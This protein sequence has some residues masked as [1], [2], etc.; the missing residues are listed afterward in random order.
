MTRTLTTV[1]AGLTLIASGGVLDA[2]T[3]KPGDPAPKLFVSEWLNGEPVKQFEEGVV[4]VVEC[5]AT[6]CG[7]CISAIPHVSELNTRYKDQKVVFIGLNVW[8]GQV[9]KVKALLEQMGPKMNY[10]VAIDEGGEQGRSA[11]A[12]LEAAGQDG[13]PCT[14]IVDRQSKIAWIGHPMEMED[15]LDRVVKGTFDIQAEAQM[16]AKLA[17]LR[18]AYG[19]AMHASDWDGA[20]KVLDEVRT[21]KPSSAASIDVARMMVLLVHKKDYNA[22]YALAKE[23]GEQS[24][25]DDPVF[26]NELAW[27]LLTDEQI[28]QRNPQVARGLAQRAVDLTESKDASILDTLARAHFDCGDVDKAVEVQTKAVAQAESD[29]ETAAKA[30]A[31]LERYKA[32]QKEAAGR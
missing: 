9:P 12:W 24:R 30:K 31:S 22:G 6:W 19:Q 23:I 17:A 27:F 21:L 2:Q 10:V 14:F 1:L 20:L 32:A 25:K 4:Y 26:L 11:A 28:E 18:E 5:W 16:Q 8:D 15:P 13:I 3:L 29:P 7:P